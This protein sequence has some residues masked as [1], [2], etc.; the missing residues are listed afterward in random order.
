MRNLT[1]ALS[2]LAVI[3]IA[4]VGYYFFFVQKQEKQLDE[5][6]NRVLTQIRDNIIQKNRTYVQ[7]AV[8]NS[9]QNIYQLNQRVIELVNEKLLREA[10]QEAELEGWNKQNMAAILRDSILESPQIDPDSTKQVKEAVEAALERNKQRQQ[11]KDQQEQQQRLK[12]ARENLF[13]LNAGVSVDTIKDVFIVSTSSNNKKR[14]ATL[15]FEEWQ[16]QS[17]RGSQLRYNISPEDKTRAPEISLDQ[18]QD[19]M[20]AFP[21]WKVNYNVWVKANESNGQVYKVSMSVGLKGFLR[22]M[23]R[24]DIF[25]GLLLIRNKSEKDESGQEQL[26]KD[27]IYASIDNPRIVNYLVD[28]SDEVRQ[29]DPRDSTRQ[30]LGTLNQLPYRIYSTEMVFQ[31]NN[32]L[33]I[34]LTERDRFDQTK[35]GISTVAIIT[36]TVFAILILLAF[37]LLKLVLMGNYERLSLGDLLLA[38][39]SALLATFLLS[40][41]IIDGY[42]YNGP[43]RKRRNQQ[44]VELA[45][46]VSGRLFREIDQI[47]AQLAYVDQGYRPQDTL[48]SIPN[49]WANDY[50]RPTLWRYPYFQSIYWTD[51]NFK[52]VNEWTVGSELA[53]QIRLSDRRYL[54]QLQDHAW[55]TMG[56]DGL[57]PFRLESLL[58]RT[59]GEQ[60]AVV[61]ISSKNRMALD[62]ERL[63]SLSETDNSVD[64][65]IAY[66]PT[67]AVFLTTKLKSLHDPVLPPG[68]GFSVI[69][70]SGTALFHSD[71]NRNLQENFLAETN[72]PSME[73]AIQNRARLITSGSY[74]GLDHEFYLQPL[75]GMP[76][77][78]AIFRETN[79][80]RS[81]HA[82]ILTMTFFL[83]AS[84]FLAGLLFILVQIM[85]NPSSP[86]LKNDQ[87]TFDWLRPDKSK[88]RSY[89]QLILMNLAQLVL[90]MI[91]SPFLSHGLAVLCLIGLMYIYTFILAFLRL[92]KNAHEEFQWEEHRR[93]VITTAAMLVIG[94]MLF[95]A[96][97]DWDILHLLSFQLIPLM[98]LVREV[99]RILL[100]AS[101]PVQHPS[102]MNEY[103]PSGKQLHWAQKLIYQFVAI[104]DILPKRAERIISELFRFLPTGLYRFFHAQRSYRIFLLSWLIILSVFPVV[105]F[106]EFAYNQ[107][108]SRLIRFGQI[109]LLKQWEAHQQREKGWWGTYVPAYAGSTVQPSFQDRPL[110]NLGVYTKAFFNTYIYPFE[111]DTFLRERIRENLILQVGERHNQL[112]LTYEL[113]P[114]PET[115]VEAYAI[116]DSVL[117]MV[118][119]YYTEQARL[120][121][122][123]PSRTS[124]SDQI[125]W[126]AF[127]ILPESGVYLLNK[128][129]KKIKRMIRMDKEQ[130]ATLYSDLPYY[131]IPGF[132][133]LWEEGSRITFYALVVV[134]LLTIYYLVKF[135]V[136]K[137]FAHDFLEQVDPD[138]LAVTEAIATL[139]RHIYLTIP[140]RSMVR[141]YLGL[142]ENKLELNRFLQSKN[143]KNRRDQYVFDLRQDD[144]WEL[145]L[146]TV[147]LIVEESASPANEE[148]E[149]QKAASKEPVRK[150][151]PQLP[152]LILDHLETRTTQQTACHLL[153]KLIDRLIEL[154]PTIVL[155]CPHT[156]VE[157]QEMIS[158]SLTGSEIDTSEKSIKRPGLS[159][160]VEVYCSQVLGEFTRIDYPLPVWHQLGYETSAANQVSA[161]LDPETS[162]NGESA[163]EESSFQRE[164]LIFS[165]STRKPEQGSSRPVAQFYFLSTAVLNHEAGLVKELVDAFI[166]EKVRTPDKQVDPALMPDLPPLLGTFGFE[167][168]DAGNSSYR[169]DWRSRTG[170]DFLLDDRTTV[171]HVKTIINAI[172]H[173]STGDAPVRIFSSQAP[174]ELVQLLMRQ[175]KQNEAY[176]HLWDRIFHRFELIEVYREF[177]HIKPEER[178]AEI[179]REECMYDPFLQGLQT[180]MRKH[181]AWLE[182]RLMDRLDSGQQPGDR[183]LREAVIVEIEQQAHL[184]YQALWNGCSEEE[185]YLI[186]DLAQDG[187]VNTFNRNGINN[188][189]RK[190]LIRRGTDSLELMNHSFRNFVL[191]VVDEEEA[192]TME[193]KIR[194]EGAWSRIRIPITLILLAVG[195]FIFYFQANWFDDTLGFI[196][197]LAATIP[198]LNSF[199]ER[200]TNL[201]LPGL[202]TFAGMFRKKSR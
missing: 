142:L 44:L 33:L 47:R 21:P 10:R 154:G 155:V 182:L 139:K 110:A 168:M 149:G 138:P 67:R 134:F 109:S 5:R 41:L 92:N 166:A 15:S 38:V 114:E 119:P 78:L 157:L 71:P 22:P 19:T 18:V 98:F 13:P 23:E 200:I 50:A 3:A 1:L 28:Q 81:T 176:I 104:L 171:D 48:T 9:P 180:Y 181:L 89:R 161:H 198:A 132:S 53:P 39:T 40:Q 30:G 125:S 99:G 112:P 144:D 24:K 65:S 164:K 179:I 77:T 6:N 68:F 94:N 129:F 105:R 27:L 118:R 143:R 2:T 70:E 36:I 126:E 127:D 42:G 72:D 29:F 202:D 188:L 66:V 177:R 103:V 82:Q 121:H 8:N 59:T 178:V 115:D 25:D 148:Q 31:G 150:L 17:T 58:A 100:P 80:Y 140:P 62:P 131:R 196:T 51:Q 49:V 75:R 167:C 57:P 152:V 96:L 145:L 165:K 184:Y 173:A 45:D 79:V 87:F 193:R 69:D 4:F 175:D 86:L 151:S 14:S 194:Q 20:A 159:S 160:S 32:L 88:R 55:T 76:L 91:V 117:S 137:F 102:W 12:K 63:A 56:G 124:G 195:V 34:G 133:G 108:S 190:G 122:R 187:L 174:Q 7:N 97:L 95:G 85:V 123:L 130:V 162:E 191:T 128:S 107:E 93:I 60:L 153:L 172:E 185:K 52:L 163:P 16:Q 83:I 73:A 46:S 106:Y 170:K 64:S 90:A 35:L 11:E 183:R 189:V 84:A 156:P 135:V 111:S 199:F 120:T 192:L 186:Y 101:K 74:L 37:P 146:R 136:R 158:T 201:R 197:A 113:T 116:F 141:D 26:V 43:D 147:N 61:S 54:N 169:L